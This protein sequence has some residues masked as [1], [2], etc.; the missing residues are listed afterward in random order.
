MCVWQL[1][2]VL[3]LLRVFLAI[4]QMSAPP[5]ALLRRLHPGF[6]GW[7][8]AVDLADNLGFASFFSAEEI[9][10]GAAARYMIDELGLSQDELPKLVDDVASL[11]AAVQAR[12]R[13]V[14]N[15]FVQRDPAELYYEHRKRERADSLSKQWSRIER[16]ELQDK[17]AQPPPPPARPLYGSR[18]QRAQAMLGDPEARHKAEDAER[19]KWL[20]RLI[21]G[22]R[23]VEAPS[24]ARASQS[25]YV[26]ELIELQ[27]GPKR[28]GTLRTRVR[29]WSKYR[30]WLQLS[31]GLS[32]PREGFHILDYILDRRAEPASR[33]TLSGILEP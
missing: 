21:E 22:L 24:I 33:A 32:H 25:K 4:P 9:A 10:T 12:L 23:A 5:S 26:V 28:A 18:L 15:S 14:S 7:L 2:Q 17:R 30:E 29:A 20:R 1:S 16:R 6:L 27:V 3:T 19:R 8:R 31:Y 13:T 11:A